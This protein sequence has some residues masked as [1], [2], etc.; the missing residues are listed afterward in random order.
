[1]EA[2]PVHRSITALLAAGVLVAPLVGGPGAAQAGASRPG[3]GGPAP[4]PVGV[5]A[6]ALVGVPAAGPDPSG[7]PARVGAAA[8]DAG[9]AAGPAVAGA[10]PAASVRITGH[11]DGP[12][13][14]LGQYG[15]YGY[16]SRSGWS[17]KQIVNHFYGGRWLRPVPAATDRSDVTVDL[18]ELAG[19]AS[20][21]VEADRRGAHLRVGSTT[22]AAG[23]HTIRRTGAVQV[24]TATAG[25]VSVDLPGVGWRSYEGSI[26]IE[27]TSVDE[28]WNR[29]P[30]ESY[31]EGV[32]PAESIASWGASGGEA[33]LEAQAIAARS[34]ALAYIAAAGRICDDQGCQVYEGDP[35][36]VA[37]LG[38]DATY[39]DRAVTA[40]AGS[41]VCTTGGSTCPAA[42]VVG[43]EYGASSGGYT[44]GGPYPAVVDAGDAVASNPYHSWSVS[45]DL[46]AVEAL[47]PGL[48]RITKLLVT[49]RNGLGSWGGRALEIQITGTAG[50]T[51]DSGA[52]FADDLG[53]L[54]DWYR[55]ASEP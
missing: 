50:T 24:V 48:G 55:F 15:A 12:G 28:T 27:S 40:T 23:A 21:T 34:Y 2:R 19:S 3:R 43:T 13:I 46:S 16:A 18:R 47:Y 7:T 39:T 45:V 1:V 5:P 51:T 32:V 42:D 4:A 31:L 35:A 20:T 49:R 54:S 9:P 6:P 26:D 22:L 52:A 17:A 29:L 25:D 8:Y 38:R 53:L 44:A 14:G 41:V 36:T 10:T 37:S 30:L 11:G 33:A